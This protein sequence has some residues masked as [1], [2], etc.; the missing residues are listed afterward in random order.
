MKQKPRKATVAGAKKSSRTR[1]SPATGRAADLV[2]TANKYLYTTRKMESAAS[3]EQGG[4]QA[5]KT[6]IMQTTTLAKPAGFEGFFFEM[7]VV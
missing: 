7:A 6:S 2:V 5:R 3:E 1:S 4:G